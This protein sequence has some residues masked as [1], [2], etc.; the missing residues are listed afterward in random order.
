MFLVIANSIPEVEPAA[1]TPAVPV[2]G[3]DTGAVAGVG[4]GALQELSSKDRGLHMLKATF[5]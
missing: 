5:I 3:A 1:A 4:A 2:F